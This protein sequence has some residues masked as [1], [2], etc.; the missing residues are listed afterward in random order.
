MTA[1]VSGNDR[2]VGIRPSPDVLIRK[3]TK[4][5]SI[6]ENR[7]GTLM[8]GGNVRLEAEELQIGVEGGCIVSAMSRMLQKRGVN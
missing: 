5:L 7:T 4:W 8:R 1:I 3:R 2:I 6:H